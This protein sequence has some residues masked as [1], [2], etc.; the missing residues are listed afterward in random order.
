MTYFISQN[1]QGRIE[2]T[3]D[4]EDLLGKVEAKS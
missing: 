3:E 2:K 1:H 4:E